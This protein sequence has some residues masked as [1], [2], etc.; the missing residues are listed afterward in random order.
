MK[1]LYNF[2]FLSALAS[3]FL[4]CVSAYGETE[5]TN[6]DL[7][8]LHTINPQI[9]IDMRYATTDNPLGM[10]L[11]PSGEC[12]LVA[13]VAYKLSGVQRELEKIGYG[14]KVWD[15]YRPYNQQLRISCEKNASFDNIE[16]YL[17]SLEHCN[18]NSRG[19]SVDVTLVC[20]DG[21]DLRMPT[22]FGCYNQGTAR[23]CNWLSAN[24]YHHVQLLEKKM[25]QFGFIPSPS[26]WWHFD[27][28]SESCYPVLDVSIIELANL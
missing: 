1:R 9:Q 5:P 22:D 7:V 24:V 18:G 28:R 26:E 10:P 27:Y 4:I 13:E 19:T 15:A 2:L 23:D 12:Y 25:E 21:C 14:L 6:Y 8:N 20:Y 3:S 17:Y 11:Y 16:A